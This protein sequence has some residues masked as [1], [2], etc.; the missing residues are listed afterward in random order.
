MS[1]FK[2]SQ[3]GTTEQEPTINILPSLD[4]NMN[5]IRSA[6][7]HT[8][9]LQ[10][11]DVTWN[12]KPGIIVYLETM[13]DSKQFQSIFLSPLSEDKFTGRIDEL[14]GSPD[15]NQTDQLNEVV[16]HLLQGSCAIFL[17]GK[18]TCYLFNIVQTNPR[19]TDEPDSEK[20]VR[21]SHQ[22]F[23]ESLDV[24][25]NL[26]RGRVQNRQLKIEYLNLGTQ[27]N[28]RIAIVYMH[29]IANSTT[30]EMVRNRLN[31]ITSDVVYSPGY[32]QEDIEDSPF[33]PFKQVLLTER[34]DRVDANLTEGRIVVMSDGSSDALITPVTF[35]SF[36]QSPDDYNIRF[37]SGSLFR[38]LR[39]FC[40]FGTLIF[41]AMYIAIIGFHFEMIPYD[42][43][44][45]VKS[46]IENI[47]FSPFIEALIMLTT[48]ELIREAGIRLP[49]PIGQT[50]G[51]VGG[52][53][54]GESVVNAGLISNMMVI[55]IALTAIM[56]FCIP[57]YEMGNTVRFLS[58]I[59]MIGAATLGF[60][61]IVFTFMIIF[62]HLCKLETFGT[63]Y[64]SPLIP[65]HFKELRDALIRSPSW[66]ID[67]RPKDLHT[68]KPI[69]K[70][71]GR[72][73]D[74]HDE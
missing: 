15:M 40:F 73:W 67:Y 30:V 4:E 64:L 60:V 72:K 35:F 28:S 43:I 29:N 39:I 44:G 16:T 24:N 51:I 20:T 3:Q 11:I 31:D 69:R 61:G 38:L 13:I 62:I 49:S 59:V 18:M 37:F 8:A 56:S 26:I 55:V 17:Q 65:T 19:S 22:G 1:F 68:Q 58:I 27:T 71:M 46:S 7:Y 48:I 54:I 36:F 33:S 57:S 50:I 25:L 45:L 14:I 23:I 52:L 2:K 21:G 9:D 41:P 47:P 74:Q 63:P 66:T 32:I 12:E 10:A 5:Y 34:P 6:L 42:L 70:R 53:I